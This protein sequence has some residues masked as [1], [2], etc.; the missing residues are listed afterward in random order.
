M[1]S[2]VNHVLIV[3]ASIGSG[4]TQ[5]ANAVKAEL[6][7]QHP[8]I[9]VAVVDFLEGD[10]FS[11]NT[12]IKETYLKMIDV[13]PDMYDLLYRWSQASH[14]GTT[15]RNLMSW[16]L[17]KRILRL[18]D[19]YR[20]DLIVFTHPFPC[21]AACHLKRKEMLTI[22]LAGVITDYAVHRL[23]L[24]NE[25]D[26]YFVAVPDLKENLIQQG[27][28]AEKIHITG[29]PISSSFGE[30]GAAPRTVKANDGPAT[31]LIMGGGQGLGAVV[32]VLTEL[33]KI[34][35]QYRFVV[36]AGR[37]AGLRKDLQLLS[38]SLKHPVQVIGYTRR[39]PELM[40]DA[41]LLVTKPGALTC[42]EALAA[43]LPMVLVNAIP[44]QEEE[45][46]RHLAQNG[47]AIWAEEKSQLNRT[48]QQLLANPLLLQA[49]REQ[50][51]RMG[52][53]D[54]ARQIVRQLIGNR[55][56]TVIRKRR[57]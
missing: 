33:D 16:I 15:V 24:Y 50:A 48:V 3:S 27:I 35:G 37:N 56:T 54:A 52:R 44:G 10:N 36:V 49:M 11:L 1:L 21:G 5:A 20:P 12:F 22:P 23:W 7:R 31:I 32:E 34:E 17:K 53:P 2:C 55:K 25:V 28:A 57:G 14:N 6:E 38:R 43:G 18:I 8:D 47:A 42:S 9:R 45:N 26:S 19:R 41:D 39:I 29:I 40:A 46:A 30:V 13:F 4:H 51:Q